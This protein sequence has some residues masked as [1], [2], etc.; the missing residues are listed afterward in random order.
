MARLDWL[1][2]PL[3]Q[4]C[5]RR[6]NYSYSQYCNLLSYPT[7]VWTC[8]RLPLP[9]PTPHFLVWF[10]ASVIGSSTP[11][12]VCS[13]ITRFMD[14]RWRRMI[15]GIFWLIR[16]DVTDWR[17]SFT[18]TSTLILTKRHLGYAN[19]FLYLLIWC[20]KGILPALGGVVLGSVQSLNG[21][22]LTEGERDIQD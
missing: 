15:G 21:L 9:L 2:N 7:C 19:S 1:E 18:V 13:C 4:Y 5:T 8:M 22:T 3:I 10:L 12:S 17:C 14:V 11:P 16:H 6:S 20:M